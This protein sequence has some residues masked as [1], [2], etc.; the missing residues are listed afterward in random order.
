MT[1]STSTTTARS[2][3][4][5][6]EVRLNLFAGSN[7]RITFNKDALG[8]LGFKAVEFDSVKAMLQTAVLPQEAFLP[9]LNIRKSV[10][11]F[12]AKR[13]INHDLMGRIFNPNERIE[14]VT[15]LKEEQV[16]YAEAKVDFLTNYAS[17]ANGQLEKV[18][19]S[20]IIKHLDPEPLVDAVRLKQPSASYYDRKLEFRFLDLSIELNSEEWNEEIDK[21]NSDI[22]ARTVYECKRDAE[23]IRDLP[24]ALGK[25]KAMLSLAGRFK[26]LDFYVPGL[27]KL[28]LEIEV[29]VSSLGGLKAGKSYTAKEVLMLTGLAKQLSQNSHSLIAKGS[30]LSTYMSAEANRIEAMFADEEQE[31]LDVSVAES[32]APA[33]VKSTEAKVNPVVNP[34]TQTVGAFAF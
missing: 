27:K 3:N 16:K 11:E 18:R 13:G 26:S 29:T 28:A 1:N 4:E 20:A 17:Y 15:F 22:Q 34:S 10:Q 32:V 12:L 31:T 5:F 2:Q 7:Q 23:K 8:S 9:F 6:F 14:I 24:N 21:I 25:A 33:P 30:S 19:A